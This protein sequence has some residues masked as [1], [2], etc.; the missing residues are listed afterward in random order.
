MT[1]RIDSVFIT[2]SVV[3]TKSKERHKFHMMYIF[4]T[5]Q[6]TYIYIYNLQYIVHVYYL[7]TNTFNETLD[8]N[9]LKQLHTTSS[10][11]TSYSILLLQLDP[12]K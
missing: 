10:T 2:R 3:C 6:N 1:V 4:D 8:R 12:Q 7:E 11:S 9:K 5:V